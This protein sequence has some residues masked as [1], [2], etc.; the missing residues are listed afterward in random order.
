MAEPADLNRRERRKREL[1]GR[2]LE[3]AAALFEGQGF[4]ETKVADICVQA[5][6]AHK[7]FFN[8]FPTKLD[9]LR[10]IAHDG[11]E[12]LVLDIEDIRKAER[13]TPER[14]H[15]FFDTVAEQIA[16][17]GPGNRELLT[18]AVHLISG[19]A[20]ERSDQVRRLRAAFTA[21]VED[22]IARGD[23]TRRHDVES[24]TELIIGAYYVL[25]FNYANLDDFPVRERARATG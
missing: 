20:A 3:V 17:A 1:H 9:L 15:R 13:G 22:G 4:H 25:I 21:I 7:T 10:E 16:E 19:D 23:V 14:I 18:Q 5:D 2:I 11:V 6:I 8:H 24:L 12:Q